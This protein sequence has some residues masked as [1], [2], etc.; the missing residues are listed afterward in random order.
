MT[1]GEGAA[2][3]GVDLGRRRF[4]RQFAAEVFQT[5]ASV[6]GAATALQRS[7]AQAAGAILNPDA[8]LLAPLAEPVV[9]AGPGAAQ[10]VRSE[11]FSRPIARPL[12]ANPTGFRSAFRVDDEHLVLVDQRRLP[13]ELA[14]LEVRSAVELAHELREWTIG[15]GPA[16]GQ[17]AA[18]AM[19]LT[20][21]RSRTA[22]PYGR[23]AILRAGAGQLSAARPTSRYVIAAVE[24][25]MAA[26]E[27]AGEFA[28]DGEAV[29]GAIRAEA[30]AI[31]REATSDHGRIGRLGILLLPK[32]ERPVGILV[33]GSIGALAGGQVGTVM[34]V[35]R[36]AVDAGREVLVHVA[37]TRP[38]LTG[39]RLTAWELEQAGIAHIVVADN[40]VGWLL[41]AGRIDLVLVGAERIAANGD[42]GAEIGTYP[43]AVLAE[44]HRIPFAVCA[45]IV[46]VDFRTA[47][48]R[49]MPVEQG[50][51]GAVA[52]IGDV[53][54]ALPNAS[55]LNPLIDVTPAELVSVIVTEEGQVRAPYDRGIVG[56]WH[57]RT[58]RHG[59]PRTGGPVP[60]ATERTAT[61][62]A[63]TEPP[64]SGPDVR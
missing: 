52:R 3:A 5:A 49:A 29:A 40:A 56:A 47:D 45:P 57:A 59:V 20:A 63:A 17:A 18:V 53:A 55:V 13:G 12:M 28:E 25:I 2:H 11:T 41:E 31:L 6:A 16:A 54:I 26:Y 19:A 46:A 34:A 7:T 51:A 44:R 61:E 38:P 32:V 64:A 22:K 9:E 62:Q 33:R 10:V 42:V 24:R 14:E 15:P 60:A 48:G 30:D 36:A 39:A 21:A 23:R 37:E 8:A 27:A 4:F 58:V 43:V 50:A 35:L 1:P